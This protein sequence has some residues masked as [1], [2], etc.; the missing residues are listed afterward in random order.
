MARIGYGPA[1]SLETIES[2]L[3]RALVLVEQDPFWNYPDRQRLERALDKLEYLLL[4]DYLPSMS[5]AK[6]QAVLPTTT[7]FEKTP[8]TLV[9]Q[10]GR[11]QRIFPVHLGGVPLSEV[12]LHFPLQLS[13]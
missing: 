7:I 2:G 8:M 6:A 4:L 5:A 11:V 3:V 13:E 12:S 1:H 9:N 10:E